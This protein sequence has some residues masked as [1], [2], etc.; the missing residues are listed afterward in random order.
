[1]RKR[2]NFIVKLLVS[3]LVIVLV[4]ASLF[5][6]FFLVNRYR[7]TEKNIRMQMEAAA[8][9]LSAQLD[10]V[11]S[12]MSFISI[13][14]L[15]R[16]DFFQTAKK[17][18]Y[19]SRTVQAQREYYRI[20]ADYM[21]T[22]AMARSIY[23]IIFF[24]PEGYFI[25][26]YHYNIDYHYGSRI[27]P[28]LIESLAWLPAV[29]EKAGGEYL[30]AVQ[31][32]PFFEEDTRVIGLGR[33]IRDP[34]RIIGYLI[35]QADMSS[36]DYLFE[37]ARQLHAAVQIL[38]DGRVILQ[39][40]KDPAAW[41]QEIHVSF[42]SP[43]TG[44]SV[45]LT[46]PKTDIY[47][48]LISTM[49]VIGVQIA[50]FLALMISCILFY[51]RKLSK[52]MTALTKQMQ[53]LT[54]ENLDGDPEIEIYHDYSEIEYLSTAFLEM[55]NRLNSMIN[56]TIV[57]RSLQ[58]EEHFR[59]LQ[60]QINPHFIYN[61]LN[62]IGIMGQERGA[63]RINDACI[64]LAELLRYSISDP[65]SNAAFREEFSNIRSYL[66]LMK[67]RYEHKLDYELSLD[68]R[69]EAVQLPKLVLQPFVENA[70]KYAFDQEHKIIRIT[71]TAEV[72]KGGW[73]ICIQDN[74]RGF[75]EDTLKSVRQELEGFLS[76]DYDRTQ[77]GQERQGLG[78]RNTIAR[79]CLYEETCTYELG[80]GVA[81]GA[82]VLLYSERKR[83]SDGYDTVSGDDR[84]G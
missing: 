7:E 35:I 48:V 12:D 14:L 55:R 68:E 10:S 69:L 9:T 62:V 63:E 26:N 75:S 19:N 43:N 6:G 51:S 73:R 60:S 11:Y 78:I 52:P 50:L 16:G 40:G 25:S 28:A 74:G 76:R 32:N 24:N 65:Y 81:G 29:E 82:R 47:Q 71:V 13:D 67:L 41:K 70:I 45:E 80:N 27:D 2:K 49:G 84:G 61:T 21:T 37:N 83:R 72:W 64:K 42:T 77:I 33:A 22:Y 57:A 30:I 79:L 54:L 56:E 8:E 20:L 38:Q 66:E 58:L 17:L 31:N 39:D 36:L 5:F 53:R 1:M 46:K 4:P 34:G 15:S 44:I 18:Y 3:Y 59:A 23:Q